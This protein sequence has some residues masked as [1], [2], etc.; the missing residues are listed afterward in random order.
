MKDI[1]LIIIGILGLGYGI[2]ILYSIIMKKLWVDR[3][4]KEKSG[5]PFSIFRSP[6]LNKIN[7]IWISIVIIIFCGGLIFALMQE[8][9]F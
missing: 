6:L 7:L 8:I 5:I 4:C 2:Y 9:L 3:L 1:A